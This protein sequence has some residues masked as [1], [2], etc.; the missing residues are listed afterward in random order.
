MRLICD[1]P[2]A[3]SSNTL[4]L[5]LSRTS[6]EGLLTRCCQF[7]R[8]VLKEKAKPTHHVVGQAATLYSSSVGDTVLG[9][10]SKSCTA[11]SPCM[12]KF[13]ERSLLTGRRRELH[14]SCDRQCTLPATQYLK[15][16]LTRGS[17]RGWC[18]ICLVGN[19][20]HTEIRGYGHAGARANLTKSHTGIQQNNEASFV[21]TVFVMYIA[22]TMCDG[23]LHCPWFVFNVFMVSLHGD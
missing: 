3:E 7:R 5:A 6:I 16:G 14:G 23:V 15:E 8:V 10:S 2:S 21:F 19:V 1:Q 9:L 18:L 11:S 22:T 4:S 20:K 12:H 13:L 17:V